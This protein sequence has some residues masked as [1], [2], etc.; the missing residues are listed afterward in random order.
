MA[1]TNYKITENE[2]NDNKVESAPDVLSDTANNNKKVF[3]NLAKLIVNKHNG[4]IDNINS[5]FVDTDEFGEGLTVSDK[6]RWRYALS[7]GT[8]IGLNFS[9]NITQITTGYR[10]IVGDIDGLTE[11]DFMNCYLN[12]NG[13]DYECADSYTSGTSVHTSCTVNNI[14]VNIIYDTGN[15]NI[16]LEHTENPL[17]T[18]YWNVSIYRSVAEKVPRKAL[19]SAIANDGYTELSDTID[20]MYTELD[21]RLDDVETHGGKWND[22]S[23]I[24]GLNTATATQSKT[25]ALVDDH[26][27]YVPFN[28]APVNGTTVHV[29]HVVNSTRYEVQLTVGDEDEEWQE[30]PPQGNIDIQIYYVNHVPVSVE[31]SP[32]DDV[33]SDTY[34]IQ[35]IT[36]ADQSTGYVPIT[37]TITPLEYI[38]SANLIQVRSTWHTL[39]VDGSNILSTSGS[40]LKYSTTFDGGVTV[41]GLLLFGTVS[42]YAA[43]NVLVATLPDFIKPQGAGS[44]IGSD[45]NFGVFRT[46]NGEKLVTAYCVGNKFYISWS[47][48]VSA[49]DYIVFEFTYHPRY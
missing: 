31:F 22:V 29:Y 38:D 9:G 34:Y 48:A 16:T 3:D 18:T 11:D 32:S 24:K 36:E 26:S 49:N 2:V 17:S 25:F 45:R 5:D 35:Y 30:L 33:N 19:P 40:T 14:K 20:A 47:A 23:L 43:G 41:Q 27:V 37:T 46:H 1:I 4:L 7:K 15:G 12:I 8:S 13:T 10:T 39:P 44:G 42:S 21:G 6:V 28:Y